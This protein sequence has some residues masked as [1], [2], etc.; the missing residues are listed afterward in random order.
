MPKSFAFLRAINVGGRNVTMAELRRIFEEAGCKE[1]ETFIA[2]GNV[3]FA[4]GSDSARLQDKLENQLR[5][6]LGYE[7]KVFIRTATEL[8]A[9]A[10]Y[11][12]FKDSQVQSAAALNVGLLSEPLSP[13]AT[14]SVTAMKTDNDDFHVQGR[15]VYWLCK[16][17]Q[18]DSKFT[19]VRFEKLVKARATWRNV[20]TIMRLAAKYVMK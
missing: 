14:K 19:N 2:S 17:R 9:M 1:V 20:N 11:K 13:E 10:Q 6:S 3:I 4:S 18:S 7:V 16:T 15:E 12:P 8:A 5:G